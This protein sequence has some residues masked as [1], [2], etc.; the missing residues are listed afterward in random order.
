MY[1]REYQ[2]VF[3]RKKLGVH[4]GHSRAR[5]FMPEA[6]TIRLERRHEMIETRPYIY[7]YSTLASTVETSNTARRHNLDKRD[8]FH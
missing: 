6:P 4:E 8:G 3:A 2:V 5:P 7:H 1:G